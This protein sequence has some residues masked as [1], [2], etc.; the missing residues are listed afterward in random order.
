MNTIVPPYIAF[1]PRQKLTIYFLTVIRFEIRSLWQCS[2]ITFVVVGLTFFPRTSLDAKDPV[3]SVTKDYYNAYT[4]RQQLAS[5]HILEWKKLWDARIE[6]QGNLPLAQVY[7]NFCAFILENNFFSYPLF[8]TYCIKVV[9]SSLYYIL[10]SA[11]EDWPWSLSPGS[12]S[13]N[14]YKYCFSSKHFFMA[15]GKYLVKWLMLLVDMYFG[16][17]RHGCI[18]VW[19]LYEIVST[20]SDEPLPQNKEN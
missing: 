5:L 11:R 3:Q 9:N 17:Q 6:F 14:G 10:S 12:L 8:L 7:D 18:R 1:P 20:L 19:L 4:H 2:I 15:L 13:S 16:I